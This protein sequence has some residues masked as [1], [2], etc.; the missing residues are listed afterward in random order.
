MD[1]FKEN[2]RSEGEELIGSLEEALLDLEGDFSNMDQI[3]NVFRVMHSL[4]GG[5]GMFGFSSIEEITHDLET[6]YDSIRN[7]K[8]ELSQEIFDVTYKVLDHLRVIIHDDE[9][10]EAT[11]ADNH[12]SLLQAIK[13]VSGSDSGSTDTS[14]KPKEKKEVEYFFRL[15]LKPEL[16]QNGSN[17]FFILEDLAE[18]GAVDARAFF[19]EKAELASFEANACHL[20]WFG[21]LKGKVA[22][23]DLDD[24]FMFIED[25]I[26][27]DSII[28]KVDLDKL[29][30][31]ASDEDLEIKEIVAR[32][33]PPKKSKEKSTAKPAAKAAESLR[34]RKDKLDDLMAIVS[35]I[36]TNQAALKLFLENNPDS[37]L[38]G[39]TETMEKLSRQLRDN[40]FGLT[41]TP[42]SSITTRFKR[43]IRDVASGIGKEI[44]FQIIGEETE[45]D[46]TLVEKIV[47]PV[48]HM[49]RNSVDHGIEMPDDREAKGKSREGSIT[50][51]AYYSGTHVNIE[52]KDDGKGIDPN[53]IFNKAVE[54]GIVSADSNMTDHQK[55]QLIFFP[56]FST[57]E[58]VTDLS[59]R[60][61][62]MDVVRKNIEE[63]RGEVLL[64]SEVGV[65]SVLTLKLP[66]TLSII[67][68]LIVELNSQ[69]YII[70]IPSVH[71]CFKVSK[72]EL[73][74]NFNDS[75]ELDEQEIPYLY[76]TEKF[77]L[78]NQDQKEK[79]LIVI[80]NG[81]NLVALV[82]DSLIG[83]IQAVIKPLGPYYA[84]QDY[85]SGCTILGDGSIALVLDPTR[86]VQHFAV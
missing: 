48:M 85:Y 78:E 6:V 36:V 3:S 41:L 17:P 38:E 8:F 16:I 82:F 66:L 74:S 51:S 65:G 12:K 26:I 30:L 14:D 42:I 19:S 69:R 86:L 84:D 72:E 67:D 28:K 59:G 83:E 13:G 24:L 58:A 35:E 46:K 44:D 80:E 29:K 22:Q 4:K 25:E 21:T 27:F 62:G 20:F 45:L 61:V 1:E 31:T 75:V 43:L 39:I 23:D 40:A 55:L 11:N 49:L 52:I 2:F 15:K 68:G 50:L 34:V 7:G 64:S 60:G 47:D 63:L 33:E 70:P 77:K 32:I 54:K 37:K 5:A 53:I 56:G 71:K 79:D 18:L 57:A 81:A 76:L 10:Q 73:E 9:L